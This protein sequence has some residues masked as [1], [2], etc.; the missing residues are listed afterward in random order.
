MDLTPLW[1]FLFAAFRDT[2][3]GVAAVVTAAYMASAIISLVVDVFSP[4]EI[5]QS[6]QSFT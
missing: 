3:F 1:L 2:F 4:R 6:D 5:Q